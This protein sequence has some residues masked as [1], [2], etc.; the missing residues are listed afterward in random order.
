MTIFTVKLPEQESLSRNNFI[1]RCFFNAFALFG[2]RA[3]KNGA[4]IFF[5]FF[6][7]FFPFE[8]FAQKVISDIPLDDSLKK[9]ITKIQKKE[10]LRDSSVI[11]LRLE[12][13]EIQKKI[14]GLSLEETLEEKQPFF[15]D[16]I[17]KSG[18]ISQSIN[19]GNNKDF[20]QNSLTNLEI[21][22]QMPLGMKIRAKV[23]DGDMPVDEN[24]C[25]N[26]IS[27]LSSF[28]ILVSK[29]SNF[30]S[31]GD[32]TVFSRFSSVKFS[33]K[34]RG[35]SF[36]SVNEIFENDTLEVYGDFASSKGKFL[37]MEFFGSDNSQGPYFLKTASGN[38]V[39]VLINSEKIYLDGN[40]LLR[41]E[42]YLIDYNSGT[43]EFN[44]KHVITSQ[45][46]I[47]A[48]F[49]YIESYFSN[50]F[51]CG[52]LSIKHNKNIFK[53]GYLCEEDLLNFTG[54][55]SEN[56]ISVMKNSSFNTGEIYCGDTLFPCPK[57]KDFFMF[58]SG[59]N[60]VKNTFIGIEGCFSQNCFNRLASQG[61]NNKSFSCSAD[62]KRDFFLKDTLK[63]FSAVFNSEFIS[64]GFSP[65]S[66]YKNVNFVNDWNIENYE[67]GNEEKTFTAGLKYSDTVF[68]ADYKFLYCGILDLMNGYANVFKTG[69]KRKIF[70]FSFNSDYYASY[71]S[72]T[73]FRHLRNVFSSSFNFKKIEAGFGVSQFSSDKGGENFNF[74][75]FSCYA[76]KR[77][78]LWNFKITAVNRKIFS[79]FGFE[80]SCGGLRYLLLE[81]N[82]LKNKNFGIKLTECLKQSSTLEN[83]KFN[84]LT[85]GVESTFSLL[86]NQLNFKINYLSSC[87]VTEKLAYKFI[88]TTPGNGYFTWIDYNGDNLEDLN[89]FENAYYKTDADYV[90]Y[91]VH[92][93][94]Y[95]N[96]LENSLESFLKFSGKKT[97]RGFSKFSSRLS[98]EISYNYSSY[99]SLKGKNAFFSG[100]SL[101]D[102]S[103]IRDYKIK[104]RTFKTF[105]L[106]AEL[107]KNETEKTTF[108]GL[109]RAFNGLK[110]VFGEFTLGNFTFK[111]DFMKGIQE[112]FSEFFSDKNYN[113]FSSGYKTGLK[114]DF[115][116]FLPEF[117]YSDKLKYDENSL[118]R[119][120]QK[121]FMLSLNYLRSEKYS[122][123]VSTSLVFNRLRSSDDNPSLKY[124]LLEGLQEG[125]N[126]VSFCNLSCFLNRYLLLTLEY[127][128]R[129][130]PQSRFINT[131]KLE[132][133]VV[134]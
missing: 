81:F 9:I 22:S 48:D 91:F 127:E 77:K 4:E 76:L 79:D 46:R 60:S 94:Q 106:G 50:L 98:L 87:G 24:G 71:F 110:S 68:F 118:N 36:F 104:I 55:L 27:Q 63:K 82:R 108:Y 96:T 31:F 101:I 130:S 6:I 92:T 41:D 107:M 56:C 49:E 42:D 97:D 121:T 103:Q 7:V 58:G 73:L 124:R 119:L 34:I 38:N 16:S 35:M 29:D 74:T 85:G 93:G 83:R 18:Y 95:I 20:S 8:I 25:T 13:S 1:S 21:S 32:T 67:S 90:K 3:L 14:L 11:V 126:L 33:K 69:Y 84:S 59:I 116:K 120:F 39:I 51:L 5:L 111:Q 30:L 62:F 12:P 61:G 15:S 89:E 117:S 112:N 28:N 54:T 23:Y 53:A 128:L 52:G 72:D 47:T 102:K 134:L 78:D 45:S 131:G 43:I 115:G 88:K 125:R 113:F 105:F 123:M 75:D 44:V 114:A 122:A 80:N 2:I 133:K 99:E 37:R 64:K 19:G 57:R 26:Q 86:K 66:L 65:V 109:E 17:Q 40:L 70:S 132:L 10:F 100:D 129:K